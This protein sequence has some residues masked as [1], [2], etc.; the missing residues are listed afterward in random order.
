MAAKFPFML[1]LCMVLLCWYNGNG[2]ALLAIPVVMVAELDWRIKRAGRF[3]Y[4][5]CIGHLALLACTV[6]TP[7][8]RGRWMQ[9]IQRDW[10]RRGRRTER[11]RR[12]QPRRKPHPR[13]PPV[14]TTAWRGCAHGFR[15]SRGPRLPMTVLRRLTISRH[16]CTAWRP[17]M[18]WTRWASIRL[19]GVV[20]R[21]SRAPATSWIRSNAGWLRVRGS[22][23]RSSTR[24]R[25]TLA[26]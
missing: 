22:T 24:I 8:Y 14:R 10:R 26:A 18:V 13:R 4:L 23:S 5:Y 20:A 6:C 19:A 11:E 9:Q 7:S 2:W 3:F 21:P 15:A 1:R 25:L 12:S 17:A 16:V